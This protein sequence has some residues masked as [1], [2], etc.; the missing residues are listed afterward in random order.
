M[1]YQLFTRLTGNPVRRFFCGT[2]ATAAH[3]KSGCPLPRS[4]RHP[5]DAAGE[6]PLYFCLSD[7]VSLQ[8]DAF[9]FRRLQQLAVR[10]LH[11]FNAFHQSIVH[12]VRTESKGV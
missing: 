5:L 4:G 1:R 6:I 9:F 2:I 11:I 3:K 10:P 12:F 8:V 7:S